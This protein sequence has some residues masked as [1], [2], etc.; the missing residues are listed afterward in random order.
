MDGF[1]AR[2]SDSARPCLLRLLLLQLPSIA[3]R[4]EYRT[5]AVLVDE[6]FPF[7]FNCIGS[8]RR[9]DES[10]LLSNCSICNGFDSIVV[11]S[12]VQL[13][14]LPKSGGGGGKLS[15]SGKKASSMPNG[16]KDELL[17]LFLLSKCCGKKEL[18]GA[19]CCSSW[20]W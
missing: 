15:E 16:W 8:N 20:S 3:F 1:V 4:L 2:L 9:N 6:S 13:T 11:S 14:L 5:W 19:L 12:L 18:G 17:S 10:N 7:A